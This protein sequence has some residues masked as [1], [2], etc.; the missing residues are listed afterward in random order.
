MD[1]KERS[2]ARGVHLTR[3]TLLIKT[4]TTKREKQKLDIRIIANYNSNKMSDHEGKI[5]KRRSTSYINHKEYLER[6]D[7]Y[8][9]LYWYYLCKNKSTLYLRAIQFASIRLT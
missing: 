7:I 9:D 1:R 4:E 8:R 2:H 5:P 3:V 6:A